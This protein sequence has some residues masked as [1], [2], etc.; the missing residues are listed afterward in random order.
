VQ[1]TDSLN[2]LINFLSKVEH[3]EDLY[4]ENFGYVLMNMKICCYDLEGVDSKT[5]IPFFFVLLY[6]IL[7]FFYS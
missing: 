7:F 4:G 2:D 3:I 5:L 6:F 1:R